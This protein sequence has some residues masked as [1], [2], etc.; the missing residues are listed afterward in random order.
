M[1]DLAALQRELY[2]VVTSGAA[3]APPAWLGSSRHLG[4]YADAYGARLH[5]VLAGDYPKLRAAVGDEAFRQLAAAYLR[6]HPPTSFTVRDAGAALAVFAA[7]HPGAPPWAADLAALERARVE[8]FD[9]ADAESASRAAVA[10]LGPERF[11]ELP[12]AL[13]PAS[14]IV[15]LAWAVDELWS[16]LEDGEELAGEGRAGVAAA[17]R[18]CAPGSRAVLVWRH[19]LRVLHRTLD[20]DEIELA[21]R[22]AAGAC[23]S[24]LAERL[25]AGGAPDPGARLTELLVRWLDSGALRAPPDAGA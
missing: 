8:V 13:V 16:T 20:P 14:A 10:A 7:V 11:A 24:E 21:Q 22:V 18:A 3:G 17:P 2:R 5:D 25:T 19:E 9:A 15:P 4:V 1:R 23:A 6:A 12:L